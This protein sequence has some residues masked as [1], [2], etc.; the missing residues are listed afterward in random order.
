MYRDQLGEVVCKYWGLNHC[1]YSVFTRSQSSGHVDDAIYICILHVTECSLAFTKVCLSFESSLAELAKTRIEACVSDIDG[2]M[3]RNLL[4][5]NRSKT[6][7]LILNAKH[8]PSPPIAAVTIVMQWLIHQ[9]LLEISVQYA[10]PH[11]LWKNMLK[12]PVNLPSSI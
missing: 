1:L 4:K 12:H 2:W 8:C 7:L 6:E 10:T 5:L 11:C 3:L 9:K